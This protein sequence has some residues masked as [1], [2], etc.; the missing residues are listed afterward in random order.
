VSIDDQ[1]EVCRP[2]IERQ[3]CTLVEIYAD[4]AP[5]ARA[6]SAYA[7]TPFPDASMSSCVKASTDSAATYRTSR[8]YSTS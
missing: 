1:S 2:H 5:S 4:P 7:P 6:F 3:G 8:G